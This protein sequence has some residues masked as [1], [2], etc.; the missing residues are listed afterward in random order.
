MEET[1]TRFP[2]PFALVEVARTYF[3]VRFIQAEIGIGQFEERNNY[4]SAC[5]GVPYE[6]MKSRALSSAQSRQR[7]ALDEVALG[8]KEEDDD[9]QHDEGGRRH[10]E[11]RFAAV[12]LLV[13]LQSVGE[14]HFFG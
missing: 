2:L 14:R 11:A 6:A 1:K 5:L 7:G 8:E 13:E 3:E 4:D 9:G 10:E 12:I